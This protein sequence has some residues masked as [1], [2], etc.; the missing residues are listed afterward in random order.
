MADSFDYVSS[1]VRTRTHLLLGYI[2]IVKKYIQSPEYLLLLSV[3]LMLSVV[4]HTASANTTHKGG[5]GQAG[6]I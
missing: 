2:F 4:T 5:K 3:C 1:C 6:K